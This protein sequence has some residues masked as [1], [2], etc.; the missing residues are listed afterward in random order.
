MGRGAA[1][2]AAR[3]CGA[4]LLIAFLDTNVI[5]RHLTGDPPEQAARATA[6][7]ANADRLLLADL[8]VAECVYVL[9]SF[10]EVERARIAELMRAAIALS[11]VSVIDASL[12]RRALEIYEHD[13]L[14]FAEAYLVAQ[15]EMTGVG[16]VLTFDRAVDRV[17]SVTRLAP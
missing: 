8:V 5:I 7:L 9:Q 1:A 3:A 14:D 10:Y 17:A 2:V 4:G 15:A 13:R 16:A 11:S 12:L 6:A